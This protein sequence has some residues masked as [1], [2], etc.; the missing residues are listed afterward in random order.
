MILIK[1]KRSFGKWGGSSL[2]DCKKLFRVSRAGGGSSAGLSWVSI[3]IADSTD[4]ARGTRPGVT[5]RL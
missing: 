2:R 5:E 4:D 3:T 1:E